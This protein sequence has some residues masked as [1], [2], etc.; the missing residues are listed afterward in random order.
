MRKFTF[1]VFLLAGLSVAAQFRNPGRGIRQAPNRNQQNNTQPF[2]EFSPERAIGITYYNPEKAA[3]KIKLKKSK[4][5]FGTFKKMILK[6]NK[7]V[8][9]IARI[10]SFMFL[11]AK[12]K[13]DGAQKLATESRDYTL[14]RTAF[15]EVGETF[16]P[17][18]DIITEKEK[19][20]DSLVK[21]LLNDKQ[22]K[23]WKKYKENQKTK[24]PK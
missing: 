20:L 8:K 3:K 24:R 1:L 9:D 19:K 13:V 22:F 12:Q 17:I 7:D 5:E 2:P 14:L 10:N 16:K 18:V 21:P 11:E 4:D 23:K 6:F 15:K